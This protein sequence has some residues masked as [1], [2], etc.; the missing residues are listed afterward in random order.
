MERSFCGKDVG[1][2]L[3]VWA[4]LRQEPK[5]LGKPGPLSFVNFPSSPTALTFC[6]VWQYRV[7]YSWD[8]RNVFFL[9]LLL[10]TWEKQG[11]F[12]PCLIPAGRLPWHPCFLHLF[13][14]QVN[15][16]CSCCMIV[17]TNCRNSAQFWVSWLSMAVNCYFASGGILQSLSH[18]TV[19]S[20]NI[21][22]GGPILAQW[23]ERVLQR[24][25]FIRLSCWIGSFSVDIA[26][27]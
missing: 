17:Y 10:K 9:I 3:V 26:I 12:I 4:K 6:T 22:G 5:L 20:C 21:A 24:V 25:V 23:T 16:C 27:V 8:L 19:N 13:C 11:V 18:C 14:G 7:S 15:G 2:F 1:R